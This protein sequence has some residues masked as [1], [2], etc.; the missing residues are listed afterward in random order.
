[1]NFQHVRLTVALSLA[2]I[3]VGHATATV[4]A[5][6][7]KSLGGDKLTVWGAEKGASADGQIP[8]YQ[9]TPIKAPASY[10]PGSGNF[11]DPFPNEKPL[12]SVNAANLAQ[13]GDLVTEGTKGLMQKYADF[14]IDV[15]PTHRTSRYPKFW[16]DGTLKNATAAKTLPDCLGVTDVVPGVPFPIPRTGCEVLW[17]VN[18]AY[19]GVSE[20][21][22][23]FGRLIDA[24]GNRVPIGDVAR[25]RTFVYADPANAGKEVE[26]GDK[27]IAEQVSPPTAA[28]TKTALWYPLDYTK[29]NYLAWVYTPGQ[30]RVRQAPEFAYDTP[31]ASYGGAILYD[32]IGM[33]S[34]KPDRFDFKLVGKKEMLIPANNYRATMQTKADEITGPK[35]LDPNRVRWER[36]R[37]WVLEATLKPGKRHVYSKRRFYVDEDAWGIIATESYDQSGKLYRTGYLVHTLGYELPVAHSDSFFNFYNLV[38]GEYVFAAGDPTGYVKTSDKPI[39]ELLLAPTAMGGSGIR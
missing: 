31:A 33:F 15:Y 38:S 22:M 25:I 14:R 30:R 19:R 16:L 5:E 23:S 9:D 12:F 3:F 35:F 1:M 36:R 18:M 21:T 7:A 32:E 27:R 37:V 4:T 29:H 13:Y 17:N 10:K 24:S 2:A 8:A 26:Y 39:S 28:G 11:P 20:R 34:G 6:E